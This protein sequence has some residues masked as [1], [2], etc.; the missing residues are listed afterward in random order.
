MNWSV[1]EVGLVPP[2]VVTVTSTLPVPAGAKTLIWVLDSCVTLAELAPNAT[3]APVAKPVPV[4]VTVV[5][6]EPE[7]GLTDDTVGTTK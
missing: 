7:A 3:C 5:P 4:T 2:G 1:V 6:R